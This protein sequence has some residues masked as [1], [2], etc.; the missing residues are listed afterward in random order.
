M[1]EVD[2]T[3]GCLLGFYMGNGI[4]ANS[5]RVYKWCPFWGKMGTTTARVT[6]ITRAND[7]YSKSR[8][9]V[10]FGS[11]ISGH[12][13]WDITNPKEKMVRRMLQLLQQRAGSG[14]VLA[15]LKMPAWEPQPRMF[16]Q[17][18]S[19]A[20]GESAQ[21]APVTSMD[22]QRGAAR[23]KQRCAMPI[24]WMKSDPVE[25]RKSRNNKIGRLL[26]WTLATRSTLGEGTQKVSPTRRCVL[27]YNRCSQG[28]SHE[29][30]TKLHKISNFQKF[31]TLTGICELAHA[32]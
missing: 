17:G 13:G 26:R 9:P 24:W 30:G 21:K 8:I 5:G 22:K 12:R 11:Q 4:Q 14:P 3:L 1:F 15:L 32:R 16:K 19:S 2:T 25:I 18:Q 28:P 20:Q 27:H 7:Y 23:E 6:S 31:P 10:T 29:L